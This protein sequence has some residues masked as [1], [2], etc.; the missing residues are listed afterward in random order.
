MAML[1]KLLLLLVAT[2][3]ASRRAPAPTGPDIVL[4]PPDAV[5]GERPGVWPSN[6]TER[7]GSTVSDVSHPTLTP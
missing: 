2:V 4:F 6:L 3:D 5:P 7:D 1:N